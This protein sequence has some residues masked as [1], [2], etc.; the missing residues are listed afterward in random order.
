MI[1]N[2]GNVR[3]NSEDYEF[4]CEGEAEESFLSAIYSEPA[5]SPSVSDQMASDQPHLHEESA[6]TKKIQSRA[7]RRR[8][9]KHWMRRGGVDVLQQGGNGTYDDALCI[10]FQRKQRSIV[11][12]ASSNTLPTA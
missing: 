10:A 9:R 6:E 3:H 1:A 11:T 5:G 2:N 4:D 12:T 7:K 8:R